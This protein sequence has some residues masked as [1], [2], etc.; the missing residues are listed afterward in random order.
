MD[1]QLIYATNVTL[2]GYIED[3]S[4]AFDLFS[5]DDE[6]FAATTDLL[7]VH[8]ETADGAEAD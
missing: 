2:D 8:P 1:A 5:A 7:I 6:A 4:G 3:A